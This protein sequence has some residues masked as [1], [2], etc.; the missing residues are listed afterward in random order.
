M[1][2]TVVMTFR[3]TEY[4]RNRLRGLARVYAHG[5]MSQWLRWAAFNAQRQFLKSQDSKKKTPQTAKARGVK[6][7]SAPA[8][9]AR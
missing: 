4:E 9:S 8:R 5:D 1:N 6:R 7:A 2:K 3:V